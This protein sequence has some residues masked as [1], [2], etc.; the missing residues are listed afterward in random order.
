[1]LMGVCAQV[2]Q[3]QS[4]SRVCV[5]LSSCHFVCAPAFCVSVYR[6]LHLCGWPGVLVSGYTS[7]VCACVFPLVVPVGMWTGVTVLAPTQLRSSSPW[8]VLRYLWSCGHGGHLRGPG[9]AVHSPGGR[10]LLCGL[11]R[12]RPPHPR[13]PSPCHVKK[14]GKPLGDPDHRVFL[15]N[16]KG[17]VEKGEQMWGRGRSSCFI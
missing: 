5:S 12:H 14:E 2:C 1:M 15:P 4:H 13:R 6:Q 11:S 7:C 8:S 16:K 10:S 9:Q 17:W 3:V